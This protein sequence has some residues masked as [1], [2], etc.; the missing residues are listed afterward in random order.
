MPMPES[1]ISTRNLS[2]LSA[3]VRIRSSRAHPGQGHGLNLPL[4]SRSRSLVRAGPGRRNMGGS[5][6]NMSGAGK[7]PAARHLVI[8]DSRRIQG[9]DFID[10]SL[11]DADHSGVVFLD[12]AGSRRSLRLPALRIDH[13]DRATHLIKCGTHDLSHLR[14]ASH[15]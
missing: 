1:P 6:L 12:S 7:D 15:R 3:W 2:G 5:S 4:T 9:E 10:D 8:G 13:A 11:F 14:P